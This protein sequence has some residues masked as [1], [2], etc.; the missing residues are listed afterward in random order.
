MD[1]W[2][3]DSFFDVLGVQSVAQPSTVDQYVLLR[4]MVDKG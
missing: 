2:M 4:G 1:G 3:D